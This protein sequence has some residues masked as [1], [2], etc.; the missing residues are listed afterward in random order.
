MPRRHDKQVSVL[1]AFSR[2]LFNLWPESPGAVW[3]SPSLELQF[4]EKPT[5]VSSAFATL[6]SPKVSAKKITLMIFTEV[7]DLG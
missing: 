6:V 1:A 3:P 5:L 7:M 4:I 2:K